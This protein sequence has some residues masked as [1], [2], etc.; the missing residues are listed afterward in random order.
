MW[1]CTEKVLCNE[2]FPHGDIRRRK[3]PNFSSISS[4]GYELDTW[5]E[6]LENYSRRQLTK[7]RDKLPTIAAIAERVRDTI[8]DDYISGHFKKSLPESLLWLSCNPSGVFSKETQTTGPPSWSWASSHGEISYKAWVRTLFID[9]NDYSRTVA[10]VFSTEAKLKDPDNVFGLVKSASIK[11]RGP[12]E[13][14]QVSD[15][16]HGSPGRK[17]CFD[18]SSEHMHQQSFTLLHIRRRTWRIRNICSGEDVD[19]LL[20]LPT[21]LEQ[22]TFRRVGC[23]T[24]QSLRDGFSHNLEEKVVIIV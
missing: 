7:A 12:V 24:D 15:L 23:V 21:D 4:K 1:E 8:N 19:G 14:I 17:V 9:L 10:T 6:I 3:L 13:L 16:L 18:Y 2:T 5:A 20:L 11:I 22:N